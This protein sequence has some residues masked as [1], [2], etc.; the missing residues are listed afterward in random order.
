[1]VNLNSVG[2]SFYVLSNILLG[3][4]HK[5]G[6]KKVHRGKK[7]LFKKY[8]IPTNVILREGGKG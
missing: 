2:R 4:K 7:S 8:F 5:K 3:I 6:N 1:M